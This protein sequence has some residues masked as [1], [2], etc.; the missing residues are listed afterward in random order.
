VS[1]LAAV[2]PATGVALT[3]ASS[4]ATPPGGAGPSLLPDP[5]EGSLVGADP[6]SMLYLFESK[7]QQLAVTEGTNQISALQAERHEALQKE[8]QAIQ[9][10]M[11]AEH[12][13]SFWDDLGS[14]C[15]EVAKVA[16]VV[17]SVAAAVGT[18]GA[19]APVAALAIAGA[20][21]STASFVDGECHVLRSLGVDDTTAGWVDTGMAIGGSLLSLGAGFA[22]GGQAASAAVGRAATVVA[23]AGGI[24]SAA[25]T[26]G[27]GEALARE[28]Q[29]TADQ[30]AS[31]AQSDQATRRMQFVVD[32]T[33]SSDQQ[34]QQMLGTI[35]HTKTIQDQTA[36]STA[37]AVRG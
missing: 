18:L 26:I 29:A 15:S 2:S 16:V 19:A 28:D 17:A 24:G 34:A 7:D 10:A 33:Q 5:A 4:A 30:V 23:G 22:G 21:L 13:H 3:P 32:E 35:A 20:V 25:A 9:K 1:A 31:Q 27:K 37:A 36:M 14:V 11:Q 8:Q 6:L 12:D